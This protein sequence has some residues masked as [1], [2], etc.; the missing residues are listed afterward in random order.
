MIAREFGCDVTAGEPYRS[1]DA[2]AAAHLQP[3]L[4]LA[5]IVD[6]F[7]ARNLRVVTLIRS[8]PD[9]WD[10]YNSIQTVSLLDWLKRHPDHGDSNQRPEPFVVRRGQPRA[11]VGC[12]R[13]RG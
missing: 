5:D 13:G 2:A 4:S 7:E 11:R 8:T 10:T 3:D 6:S 9:D 1:D 12:C